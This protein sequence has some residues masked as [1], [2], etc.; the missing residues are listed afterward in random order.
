V[1]LLPEEMESEICTKPGCD[2][3]A[4]L[5]SVGTVIL[6]VDSSACLP[7]KVWVKEKLSG[8]LSVLSV[9]ATSANNLSLENFRQN[10]LIILNFCIT[11]LNRD[12]KFHLTM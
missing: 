1:Q 11:S 3:G 6:M 12:F 5:T 9:Y 8:R 7:L 10:T 4:A 2:S